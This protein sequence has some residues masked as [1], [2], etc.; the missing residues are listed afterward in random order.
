MILIEDSK[1]SQRGVISRLAIEIKTGVFVGT[2]NSRIRDNLWKRITT[3]W[4]LK[5]I[6]IFQTNT[7]QKFR[8]KLNGQ[9]KKELVDFDGLQLLSLPRRK[10]RISPGGESQG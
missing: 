5:A 10:T 8:I 6:M 3:D 7:E 2:F 9:P 4:K 1:P